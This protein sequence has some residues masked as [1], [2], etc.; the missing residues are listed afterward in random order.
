MVEREEFETRPGGGYRWYGRIDAT[1]D[2]L[3]TSDGTL[4]NIHIGGTD[5]RWV[6]RPLSGSGHLLVKVDPDLIIEPSEPLVPPDPEPLPEPPDASPEQPGQANQADPPEN[7]AP[8]GGVATI[9]IMMMYT[10]EA[11][12]AAGG[13]A[14]MRNFAQHQIDLCNQVFANSLVANVRYRL[15]HVAHSTFPDGLTS[16]EYSTA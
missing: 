15:R 3:I 11:L 8:Q 10:A 9:D 12:A 14:Q 16:C 6:V 13:H 4:A 7:P 5:G 1:N 2:I